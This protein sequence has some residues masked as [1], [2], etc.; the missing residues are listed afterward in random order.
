ML[1]IFEVLFCK[2]ALF[3]R[4]ASIIFF[5]ETSL[6]GE[7]LAEIIIIHSFINGFATS[8][9]FCN[10]LFPQRNKSP[11]KVIET[12]SCKVLMNYLGM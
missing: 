7:I 9:T 11:C 5:C 8:L 1:Y 4:N 2:E 6:F 3:G 10:S 12:C